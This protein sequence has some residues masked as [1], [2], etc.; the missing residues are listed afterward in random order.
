MPEEIK[1]TEEQISVMFLDRVDLYDNMKKYGGS[2]VQ[3]LAECIILADS[4]NFRKLVETFPEYVKK[5]SE[6]GK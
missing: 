2:F 1:F 5:Y 6:W 3:A 4:L